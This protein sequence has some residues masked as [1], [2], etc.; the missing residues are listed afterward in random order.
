MNLRAFVVAAAVGL[1]AVGVWWLLQPAAQAPLAASAVQAVR[2]PAG[3]TSLAPVEGAAPAERVDAATPDEA[4][5]P[6]HRVFG[7]VV[8]EDQRPVAGAQAQGSGP[9]HG[10]RERDQCGQERLAAARVGAVE[11]A[12]QL[13]E[14]AAHV[15]AHGVDRQARAARDLAWGQGVE[16][17]LHDGAAVGSFETID[18]L[19]QAAQ[20]LDAGASF[21]G[22]RVRGR[23]GGALLASRRRCSSRRWPRAMRRTALKSQP[24]LTSGPGPLRRA[25]SQASWTR[26]PA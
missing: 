17:A 6:T 25:A 15:G 10:A 4:P 7:L 1:L 12:A 5:A 2:E 14:A 22:G 20:D 23:P 21:V 19:D 9:G 24:V 16:E 26:S 13:F 3:S 18:G 8:D 11:V